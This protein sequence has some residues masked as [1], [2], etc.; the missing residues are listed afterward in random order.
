MNGSDS[1]VQ[2]LDQL[3]VRVEQLQQAVAQIYMELQTLR[4]SCHVPMA[5]PAEAAEESPAPVAQDY[6]ALR[7]VD[8]RASPRRQANQVLI[9]ISS[10]L[11]DSPPFEGW[12]LDYSSVGL[13]LFVDQRIEVGAYLHVRPYHGSGQALSR[14]VQVKNCQAYLDGWRL[15][16]QLDAP[17]SPEDLHQLGLE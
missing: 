15:G 9:S 3:L 17:L 10:A 6:F 1:F 7:P 5:V 11:D 14:E 2:H 4:I 12:V 8:R 16:C 13:G